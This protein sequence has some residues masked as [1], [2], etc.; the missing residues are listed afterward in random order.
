MEASRSG[1]LLVKFFSNCQKGDKFDTA[2]CIAIATGIKPNNKGFFEL[3]DFSD[4]TEFKYR[5]EEY[6]RNP[7]DII[8]IEGKFLPPAEKNRRDP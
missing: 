2:K 3:R 4:E 6:E 7:N 8:I 5:L 1:C